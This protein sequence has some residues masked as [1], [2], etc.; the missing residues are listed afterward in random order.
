MHKLTLLFDKRY[1]SISGLEL[2]I[3][4]NYSYGLKYNLLALCLASGYLNYHFLI[5]GSYSHKGYLIHAYSHFLIYLK[6]NS[7]GKKNVST[8]IIAG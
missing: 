1:D 7:F 4:T 5:N 6:T 8:T 3:I 2:N